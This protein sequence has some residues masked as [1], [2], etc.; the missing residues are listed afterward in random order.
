MANFPVTYTLQDDYGRTTTRSFTIVA[1]TFAD[2]ITALGTFTTDYAAITELEIVKYKASQ[3]VTVSD[4]AVADSNVDTGVTFSMQLADGGK[5]TVKVPGPDPAYLVAGGAVDL[6][7][8]NVAAFL[9]HFT[10]GE[11]LIS[12]GEVVTSVIKGTLDK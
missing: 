5:G 4:S 8:A 2:A 12:D 1:A 6:A 9:A 3:E 10:S 11:F 7:N